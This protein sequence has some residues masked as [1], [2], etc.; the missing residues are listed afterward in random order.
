MKVLLSIKPEFAERIFDGSKKYEYR[1]TIFKR[2]EV[3]AVVVY[4]S[5]PVGR[6]VGEFKVGRILHGDPEDL[7]TQTS[8]YSGITRSHFLEY[9]SNRAKGYAIE[10]RQASRYG[11]PICLDE[12][13]LSSPPQSFMYLSTVPCG[14]P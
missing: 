14:S 11:A 1:R 7:W 4:A 12:L 10:I 13:M 5:R 8:S 6:I 2:P 3:V 9:F